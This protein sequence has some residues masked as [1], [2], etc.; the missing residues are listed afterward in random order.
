MRTSMLGPVVVMM[1][2]LSCLL[3]G[4]FLPVQ[5]AEKTPILI[6]GSL[7]LTGGF[8]ANARW[9]ERGYRF[10]ADEVNAKGGLLGRP[11]K[12][13]IYDDKGDTKEAVSLAEKV[14]TVDK[15]DVL[16]GGYPGTA[17][18]AVMPVAEKYKKLYVGMGG[19]WTLS[20]R[21]TPI[22]SAVLPLWA[23]GPLSTFLTG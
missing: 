10:W 12:L 8:S 22:R 19:I 7:P 2:V 1:A 21:A 6:G 3:W 11:V 13:I 5:A 15:V 4:G 17:C 18:I 9:I 14:I 20:A 23:S 16:L